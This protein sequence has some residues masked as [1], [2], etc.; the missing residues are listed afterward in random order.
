MLATLVLAA[1]LAAPV[2]PL[3]KSVEVQAVVKG[4]EGGTTWFHPRGCSLPDGTVLWTLQDITGSDHFGPVHEMTSTDRGR[5]WSTPKPIPGFTRKKNA[6]GGEAGVCDVVPEFHAKTQ[7]VLA[8]GH[9]VNYRKNRFYRPQPPRWP[10]YSVRDRN[11]NWSDA[12]KLEWDDPRGASIYTCGCSQRIM[13]PDGDVLM[14]VSYNKDEKQ[15]R[16]V[17]TFLCSFDGKDLRVK[18]VGTELRGKAGR[19]FLEPSLAIIDGTYYMTIRAEDNKGH[20][21]T[22]KDGLTWSEPVAWAWDDDNAPLTMSTTQQ[23]WLVHSDGLY[24]VYTRKDDTNAAVFRWRAPLYMAKVD[25][26]T[27]RFVRST[28]RV[29]IPIVDDLKNPKAVAQ[30]GNF[31]TQAVTPEESWITVGEVVTTNWRG[32]LLIGR[33]AWTK[34]NTLAPRP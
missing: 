25:R 32:N 29:A 11:G 31:H 24:L 28:E 2:D 19:G 4:R 23:R 13:L 14:S 15:P 26:E 6:D 20:V 33:V 18:K 10:V 16:A 30:L 21:S 1:I 8:I 27:M 12:K 17:S 34:P 7:T 3:V 5:T 22:S 9:S